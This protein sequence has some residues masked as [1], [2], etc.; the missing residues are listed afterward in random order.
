MM[1]S[2]R[3]VSL[4]ALALVLAA[5]LAMLPERAMADRFTASLREQ[6][7]NFVR[8]R[9]P[10]PFESI[11]V[12]SLGDFQLRGVDTSRV[13]VELSAR[14]S[15]RTSGI[16]PVTVVLSDDDEVL[17]RGIVTTRVVSHRSIWVAAR[18]LQKGALLQESDLRSVRHESRRVPKGATTDLDS[19]LGKELERSVREGAV[20]R[21]EW[22]DLPSVVERGQRVRLVIQRSGL[23][24]EGVGRAVSDG[25]LGEE[26]RVVNLDSRREVSGR[27][28]GE[29]VVVVDF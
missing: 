21:A 11:E 12:P 6:I 28:A 14:G 1:R 16:V 9:H 15:G 10:G 7:E 2:R 3:H 13:R 20:I 25:A 17:K 23:R 27:A 22:L 24:I 5:V 18:P 19:L 29:G 4:T 26:I 8:S